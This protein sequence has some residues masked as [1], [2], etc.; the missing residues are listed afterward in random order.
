[1]RLTQPADVKKELPYQIF[2]NKAFKA[3][4][5]IEQMTPE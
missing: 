4:E 5:A 2:E 1:M 3:Q